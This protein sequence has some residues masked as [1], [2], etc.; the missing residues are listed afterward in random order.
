[1]E[2]ITFKVLP[3]VRALV[4]EARD[5]LRAELGESVSDDLLLETMARALVGGAAGRDEGLSSYQIALTTCH[6]CGL[7]TQHAAGEDVAADEVTV[8]CAKCDAQELGRVDVAQPGRATQ[9][10]PPATKR[11]VL[12]RH[13][14]RCAVPGCRQSAFI[15]VHHLDRRADGGDHQPDN[16]VALCGAH[17]RATHVG[18]LVIRGAYSSGLTFEHADGRPYG[19]PAVSPAK[20]SVLA[21]ALELLV[22][23]GFKHREA[24]SMIDRVRTHV[25]EEATVEDALR[26]ALRSAPAPTSTRTA[27]PADDPSSRPSRAGRRKPPPAERATEAS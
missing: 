15:D 23:L 27:R 7:T 1:P 3:A 12:R 8:E 19:S 21:T 11:A 4:A 17:H 10:V 18:A 16:L 14:G 20:A 25:G 24:Q 9:T 2:R 22:G 5:K 13:H 26:A 6:R